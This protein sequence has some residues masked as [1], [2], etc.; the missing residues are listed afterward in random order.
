VVGEGPGAEQR[1][2]ATFRT[3]W[4]HQAYVPY[5]T[6]RALG[7]GVSSVGPVLEAENVIYNALSLRFGRGWGL[8]LGA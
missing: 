5:L 1:V 6:S 8:V 3:S 4:V 7:C 2:F